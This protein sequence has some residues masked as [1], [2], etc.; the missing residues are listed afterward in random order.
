MRHQIS[1][2]KVEAIIFFVRVDKK[3]QNF[4]S[5]KKVNAFATEK[6]EIFISTKVME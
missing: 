6:S 5:E 4:L 2:D 3:A 1:R